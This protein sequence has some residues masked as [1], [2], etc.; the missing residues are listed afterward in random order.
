MYP[1][2][3]ETHESTE[4]FVLS[5]TLVSPSVAR[6]T[7][8]SFSFPN[9]VVCT[10]LNSS[11]RWNMVLESLDGLVEVR[12][13]GVNTYPSQYNETFKDYRS[14]TR[15]CFIHESLINTLQH[16]MD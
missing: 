15:P 14:L 9:V 16:L 7:E 3:T 12:A 11:R 6:D 2:S 1:E 4:L 13:Q 10:T 5:R 8:S